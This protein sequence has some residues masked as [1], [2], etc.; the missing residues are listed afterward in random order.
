MLKI[1]QE[2]K[3]KQTNNLKEISKTTNN[4]VYTW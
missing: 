2:K 1:E 4:T 3:N